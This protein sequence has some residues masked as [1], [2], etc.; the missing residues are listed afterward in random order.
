MSEDVEMEL[1]ACDAQDA[2]DQLAEAVAR[3]MTESP[4]GFD[5]KAAIE[6]SVK[7][8][9]T[10]DADIQAIQADPR[11]TFDRLS[12]VKGARWQWQQDK[13]L[14]ER[15][16]KIN[17]DLIEE[18]KSL[19]E[20]LEAK[21]KDLEEYKRRHLNLFLK[22]VAIKAAGYEERSGQVHL[23]L[24]GILNETEEFLEKKRS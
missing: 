13:D 9:Y 19:R 5:E 2:E 7:G 17:H 1:D 20:Q 12:F 18:N 22:L 4:K 21:D 24:I 15:P 10:A 23:G 6:Q 8:Q 3:S 11:L 14:F 16:L